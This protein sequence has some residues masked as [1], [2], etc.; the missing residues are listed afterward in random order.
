MGWRG[1][2]Y[3]LGM[4]FLIPT[5]IVLTVM[6]AWRRIK[7]GGESGVMIEGGGAGTRQLRHGTSEEFTIPAAA[8]GYVIGRNGQRV[9]GL[10]RTSGAR[11][12]FKDQQD[13]ED[14]VCRCTT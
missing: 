3:V 11:I 2:H 12:R 4:V 7:G 8:V 1:Y 5:A 14:K 10:E 9:R 13:S 6:W